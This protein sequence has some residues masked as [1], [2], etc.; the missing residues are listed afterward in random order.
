MKPK[1]LLYLSHRWLGIVMC[2]FLAMW[3]VSGV[4]MIYVGF[5]ELTN[6][7]YYAGLEPL[8]AERINH[9]PEEILTRAS[10]DTAIEQLLLTSSGK[11]PVYLLKQQGVSWQGFYA[12]S[13]EQ[14]TELSAE[15]A[16]TAAVDFYQTQHHGQTVTGK[17][18]QRLHMD[19]WSVSNGLNPYRPLHKIAMND[20]AGT[21]FYV[22]SLTGQVVRDTQRSERIWNWLGANLHWIYPVQLRKHRSLWEKVIIVLA[23]LGLTSVLTGATIGFMRLRLTHRYSNGSCSPYRGMLK[24]HHM[25]GLVALI[26][27]LTFF[28]SGLMSVGPW[29]IFDSNTRF[30]EQRQRYQQQEGL[31]NSAPAYSQPEAIRQLIQENSAFPVK[32]IAWHWIAGKSHLSLHGSSQEVKS[33]LSPGETELLQQKIDSHISQLIPNSNIVS[34]Q[35]LSSY[36]LYYYSHHNRYRPL[37]VL[38]VKFD[39]PEATWFHVD[40][41]TGQILNRLTDRRRLERW[42]FNGLHSFDFALLINNR[43]V[44]DLWMILLCSVGF[45]FAVTSVVISVRYLRRKKYLP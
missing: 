2:L 20:E 25:I 14:I 27:I 44:W 18:M 3:C 6:D 40:L 39:D 24:Y 31:L 9:S 45:I 42:I 16:V 8:A 17:Y 5:P 37:P 12:D 19:Q 11:R 38:R 26:F 15:A 43:P 4:V 34:Q 36:D 32:Q 10:V 30:A 23:L 1:K 35:Q 13:G 41:T 29:G 22:S 7:E 33:I 21:E 28:F